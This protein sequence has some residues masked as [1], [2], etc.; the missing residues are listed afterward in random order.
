MP[1]DQGKAERD[2][3]PFLEAA[4]E[5]ANDAVIVCD[6]DPDRGEFLIRYA[7]PMF[8]RQTGYAKSEWMGQP[9]AL[10]YGPQ[11]DQSVVERAKTALLSG[12]PIRVEL[13]KYRKDGSEFWTEVNMRPMLDGQKRITGYV[14]IQRDIDER[15]ASLAKLELLSSAMDQANDAMAIFEWRGT[16]EWRFAYVND[17]FVR[18]TGHLRDDVVGR[19][20]DF[21][22]GPQTDLEVLHDF[23][24]KLLAGESVRGEIAFHRA[25]GTV[26]WAELNGRPIS[27]P[28]GKVINTIIVYRDVTEKHFHDERLSFEAAH[29]PLTGAYNRRFFIQTLDA[30]VR[31][32]QRRD[33]SYGLLF[34]DLDDFKPINDQHGHEAGDRFLVELCAS[35]A[36][37]LR[38]GDVFARM[39]GDEFAVLLLGCTQPQG[40]RIANYML[41]LVRDFSLLWHGHRLRAGASIGVACI[42]RSVERS[43]DAMRAADEACYTAKRAGRNRVS[44]AR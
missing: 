4:V 12:L 10:L 26:F 38:R 33:V 37:R 29:D 11:T 18:L 1:A 7:N 9:P 39:G 17:T 19:N 8:E 42:D 21:L 28:A 27:N 15:I 25:D 35:I 3:L 32:A 6:Y 40:E 5:N 31:E 14:G 36:S 2:R 20:S 13:L 24:V 22:I 30:A 23:R 41:D 44:V 43:A 16:G 34:V